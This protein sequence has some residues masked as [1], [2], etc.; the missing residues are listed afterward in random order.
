MTS[1]AITEP[2]YYDDAYMSKRLS[3]IA[4]FEHI[5]GALIVEIASDKIFHFRQLQMAKDGSIC[6]LAE[7]FTPD[8]NIYLLQNSA[9][10]IGDSHFGEHEEGVFKI[11]KEIIQ[12]L[13]IK[14]IVLHDLFT[15]NS[16][17]HHEQ[18]NTVKLAQRA[19]REEISLEDEINMVARYLD[20]FSDVVPEKILIPISNHHEHLDRYLSEGRYAFDKTNLRYSLDIV[21]AMID[22]ETIPLRY[23]L[24]NQSQLKYPYKLKWLEPDKDYDI[25]GV[26]ISQHGSKGANGAYKYSVSAHNHSSAIYKGAYR[27]GTSSKLRMSYNSGL[28]SWNHS[29]CLIM[30]GGLLQLINIVYD[31]EKYTWKI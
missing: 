3:K 14:N 21:K 13:D 5:N 11:E 25:F 8:G 26:E 20:E 30:D 10:V 29:V 23:A 16:I 28:S 18:K 22:G 27:V 15:A 4:E 24:E 9:L 1:G 31:G 19:E 12:N 2:N 7:R 6:D 17:S